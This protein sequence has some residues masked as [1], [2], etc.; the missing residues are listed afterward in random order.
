MIELYKGYEIKVFWSNIEKGYVFCVFSM[1][2]EG[3]MESSPYFYEENALLG[4][5]ETIERIIQKKGNEYVHGLSNFN[6]NNQSGAC[7]Y[8]LYYLV[9]QR[10]YRSDKVDGGKGIKRV[11][12]G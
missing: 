6:Y 8:L 7:E 5:K 12:R 11:G 9:I 3:I 2:G 1:D 10:V 4:A